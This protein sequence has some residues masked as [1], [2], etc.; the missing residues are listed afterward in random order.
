[1]SRPR[2]QGG[3]GPAPALDQRAGKRG[4]CPA[5]AGDAEGW[6]LRRHA[7][8]VAVA[9]DPV[10]FSSRVSRHLKVPNGLD[11]AEHARF[12]AL[13]DRYLEPAQ[14]AAL[15]PRF[16]DLAADLARSLPRDR[17][18]E[19]VGEIGARFA[20]RAQSAWL[21][22]PAALEEALLSWMEDNGRATRSRQPARTAAVA[23]R[24]DGIVQALIADRREAGDEAPDDVTTA[25]L[26]ERIDGR[27]LCD[28]EL[29]S[30]L[31]NWTA[32]DLGSIAA[33]IGVIVHRLAADAGLQ[34]RLRDA[35]RGAV[36][37]EP[38]IDEI[39]RSDDPFT[40]NRRLATADVEIGGR[41]IRAGE[42]VVLNWAAANRDP[43]AFGDPAAHRPV[44]NASRNLV[45][46][47]G[48]HVCPGR[49][50]ATLELRLAIEELLAATAAVELA[51]G[52]GPVRESAPYG[53][54]RTV[55]ILL[56]DG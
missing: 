7:D 15:E 24:F 3:R 27:P 17:T 34:R 44:E 49:R 35:G 14:V 9:L 50:L 11:G 12:R 40:A 48:P 26:G 10:T 21:G 45:Y 56:A 29:V 16:R 37:L 39:L 2:G 20:V 46:G 38:E 5:G 53:G 19:A 25:L 30:I 4:R 8:V 41:R 13:I 32:G 42:Q 18:V 31:R 22:W 6:D 52:P 28:E 54:F 51:P 43:L 23:E 55:P 1:M 47:I 36:E 33:S